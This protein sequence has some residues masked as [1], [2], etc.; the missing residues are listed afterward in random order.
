V[1]DNESIVVIIAMV[2]VFTLL[3]GS[4]MS[5]HVIKVKH[6]ELGHCEVGTVW[7]VCK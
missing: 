2:L 6:L 1:D 4:S 7:Q 3:I 5:G